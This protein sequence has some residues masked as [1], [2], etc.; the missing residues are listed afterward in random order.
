MVYKLFLRGG[1]QCITRESNEFVIPK[2]EIHLGERSLA[3]RVQCSWRLSRACN[4]LSVR[5]K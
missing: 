4:L 2:G 3:T 5:C 1:L